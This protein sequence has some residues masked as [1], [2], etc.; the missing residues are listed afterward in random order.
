MTRSLCWLLVLVLFGTF[1]A[2]AASLV[3]ARATAGRGLPEYS[4]YSEERNGLAGAAHL[5]RQLGWEPVAVTRPIGQTRHRGLLIVAEPS[6]GLQGDGT[7]PDTA[8]ALGWVEQGNTLLLCTNR[9]TALHR[10]LG[11]Y[12]H[13]TEGAGEATTA[14]ALDDGAG[15]TEGV[16]RLVVEGQATIDAEAGLPLWWVGEEPGAVL[17][18]RGKG[19]II[20]VADPSLLTPRGLRREDN[21]LF[22]VNL[23]RRHARDGR[24]YFDEYHH[25]LHAV[26]GL[27]GYL[28]QRGWLWVV[29]PGLLLAGMA[30]WAVAVRLGPA[31]PTPAGATADA[32]EYASA[33]ARIY[34]RAGVRQP[35]ARTLAAGFLTAVARHL[36]LRRTAL[37]AEMLA[38]WRQRHPGDAGRRL[39]T[40]LR[41]VA[42][43]R[44][45]RVSERQLL[46]WARALDQF[47][48]EVSRAG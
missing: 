41:G 33:V 13:G 40:L 14:V 28:R 18:R 16:A 3:R 19:R 1:L 5:L 47:E 43:L 25:G 35:L 34:E 6:V 45:G 7:D 24:V 48:V 10:A 42:K 2:V 29:L 15:Y 30:V 26:G 44:Q 21:A 17:L 46:A 32:V 12:V 38:A 11:V 20:L 22:L 39:E 8:A 4:V 23:A 27:W 31:V 9:M 37:P 36:R